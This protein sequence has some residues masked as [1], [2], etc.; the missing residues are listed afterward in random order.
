LIA[1]SSTAP[2]GA[3][4]AA[5]SLARDGDREQGY[6]Y[7]TSRLREPQFAAVENLHPLTSRG[8]RAQLAASRIRKYRST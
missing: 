5:G 8:I 6:F 3:G 7:G 4:R 1:A 2:P